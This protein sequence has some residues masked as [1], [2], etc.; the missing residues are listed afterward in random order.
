MFFRKL[1]KNDL[2][3]ELADQFAGILFFATIAYNIFTKLYL[4][5]KYIF[6][7]RVFIHEHI[8]CE[9]SSVC[10]EVILFEIP[11]FWRK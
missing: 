9:K 5:R 10:I 3:T 6:G 1:F 7:A 2:D 11:V 8:H 4:N